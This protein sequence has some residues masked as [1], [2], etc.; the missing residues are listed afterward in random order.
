MFNFYNIHK[1]II[2]KEKIFVI[3]SLLTIFFCFYKKITKINFFFQFL[4]Q[5]IY[6]LKINSLKK[7]FNIL[8]ILF[9]FFILSILFLGIKWITV[10]SFK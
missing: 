1:K 9:Y 2:F 5:I 6:F 8:I 4:L 10:N 7:K 3:L